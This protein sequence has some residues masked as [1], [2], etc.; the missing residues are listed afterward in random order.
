MQLGK[1]IFIGTVHFQLPVVLG[2]RS[3]KVIVEVSNNMSNSL[4]GR[5]RRGRSCPPW[6]STYKM[7]SSTERRP[8]LLTFSRIMSPFFRPDEEIA[9]DLS[10]YVYQA[11]S[12]YLPASTLREIISACH[13]SYG[14]RPGPDRIRKVRIENH[15]GIFAVTLP[16]D[17]DNRPACPC[18]HCIKARCEKRDTD[19]LG[20]LEAQVSVLQKSYS[21]I[22]DRL[23]ALERRD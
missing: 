7:C 10:G 1:G 22:A 14:G 9:V 23:E 2:L 13:P 3:Y 17:S 15:S 18:L 4:G 6:R 16:L 8:Y 12:H 11:G 5:P 20:S 19:R 21:Q